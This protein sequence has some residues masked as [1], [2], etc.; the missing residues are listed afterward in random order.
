M[1]RTVKSRASN[2]NLSC[3]VLVDGNP[4]L[5][6]TMDYKVIIVWFPLTAR[7]KPR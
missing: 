4:H 6:E 5:T 1:G 3:L 7:C 2:K